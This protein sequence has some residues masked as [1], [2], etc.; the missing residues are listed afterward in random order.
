MIL[1]CIIVTALV[2]IILTTGYRKQINSDLTSLGFIFLTQQGIW[3]ESSL[4]NVIKNWGSVCPFLLGLSLLCLSLSWSQDS[5]S[6]SN[7]TPAFQS[8]G[9]GAQ[10]LLAR[11]RLFIRKGP[12]SQRFLPMSLFPEMSP[13]GT[14]ACKRDWELGDLLFQLL[15]WSTTVREKGMAMDF[16]WTTL[17]QGQII[18]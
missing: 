17:D 15:W 14:L 13:M 7:L 12:F 9:K 5:C 3:R 4:G 2:K 6:T 1:F 11:F 10:K 8:R 16:E 18:K